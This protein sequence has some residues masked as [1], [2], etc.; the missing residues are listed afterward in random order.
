MATK[1]MAIKIMAM[2]ANPITVITTIITPRVATITPAT[3]TA[4]ASRIITGTN[5]PIIRSPGLDTGT[6]VG[7]GIPTRPCCALENQP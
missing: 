4:V 1:T 6:E 2:V 7:T 5:N 3:I